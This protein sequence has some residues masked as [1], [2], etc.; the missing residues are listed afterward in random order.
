MESEQ[1][2]RPSWY[3]LLPLS[4]AACGTSTDEVCLNISDIA[5][6][7]CQ[8][9][10]RFAARDCPGLTPDTECVERYYSVWRQVTEVEPLLAS[11]IPQRQRSS[12]LD[13]VVTTS[14]PQIISAWTAG[15]LLTGVADF[16]QVISELGPGE[17]FGP[18]RL[19]HDNGDG[20]YY[21]PVKTLLVFNE[22]ELQRRLIPTGSH[23]PDPVV[24]R[25]DDGRWS[26]KGSGS[27]YGSNSDTADITFSFGWGDCFTGCSFFRTLRAIVSPSMNAVVYDL[28]GDPLP[29]Y[30]QLD[31]RTVAG[32]PP[33]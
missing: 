19:G 12:D 1:L 13:A 6:I 15:T 9:T 20:S 2:V 26:W 11:R 8:A 10:L 18:F 31:A 16:D 28:G 33:D 24:Q 32:P 27:P 17:P 30:L 5:S 4:L 29:P 7:S 3:R 25:Q 21:F 14:N 22:E 23:L